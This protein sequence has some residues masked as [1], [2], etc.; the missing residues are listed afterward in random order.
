MKFV[1]LYFLMMAVI[2]TVAIVYVNSN[3]PCELSEEHYT[4]KEGDSLWFI[5][6]QYCPDSVEMQSYIRMVRERNDLPDAT[7]YP[8]QRLIVFVE[9]D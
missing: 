1:L 9:A 6:T 5:A 3:E 4:V 8:G 2:I 7:I